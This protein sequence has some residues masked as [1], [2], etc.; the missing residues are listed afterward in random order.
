M[1][2][3]YRDADIWKQSWFLDLSPENKLIWDFITDNCSTSGLWILD[4][5]ELRRNT[6]L[7]TIN[8]PGFLS[9][10]N[11]DY[12]KI[13]GDELVKER[14]MLV[15]DGRKLWL[16]GHLMFQWSKGEIGL[17]PK[18]AAV[19]GALSNLHEHGLLEI[20]LKKKFIKIIDGL[21]GLTRVVKGYEGLGTIEE[22]EEEGEEFKDLKEDVKIPETGVTPPEEPKPPKTTSLEPLE[23]R[24]SKHGGP[25]YSEVK[26]FFCGLNNRE[27]SEAVTFW[28]E[29]E[30]KEWWIHNK[31]GPSHEIKQTRKWQMKAEQ[32]IYKQRNADI[33]RAKYKSE[34]TK[35]I[36]NS[37]YRPA[38]FT[39]TKIT[40]CAN[41]CGKL[42]TVKMGD[43]SRRMFDVCSRACYEELKVKNENSFA[44]ISD[45]LKRMSIS[46]E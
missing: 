7:K 1:K 16:T 32:W 10:V 8:I 3:K 35:K 29:Y 19:K 40:M 44:A 33:E 36:D 34:I 38:E 12:D 21:E 4:I 18:V 25:D 27:E 26:Y 2:K 13:T 24:K 11:K 41:D 28:N 30:G 31:E 23:G 39:K 22:G 9:E 42:G 15:C 6:G 46:E 43:D 14:V 37:T 5:P 20:A 17:S 45:T